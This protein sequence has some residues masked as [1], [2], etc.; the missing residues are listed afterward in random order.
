MASFAGPNLINDNLGFLFDAAN[1]D[2]YP[3]S[4]I[5][6]FDIGPSKFEG[7]F[8]NATSTG[9][10]HGPSF[11]S[12]NKGILDFGN[13]DWIRCDTLAQNFFAGR[14]KNFTLQTWVKPAFTADGT[15]GDVLFSLHVGTT[16]RFRWQV[17]SNAIFL[18]DVN[19]SGDT[20]LLYTSDAA[21]EE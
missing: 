18:S 10:G 17:K 3:G 4:G 9:S 12:D 8:Y 21:D 13:N 15:R 1:T 19:A 5:T 16:N 20:C 7:T 2:S 6:W 11:S 14:T